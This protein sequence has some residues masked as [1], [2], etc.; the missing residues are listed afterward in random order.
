MFGGKTT[1]LF[2]IVLKSKKKSPFS[3]RRSLNLPPGEWL[4]TARARNTEGWSYAE[5]VPFMFQIP[6]EVSLESQRG[7]GAGATARSSLAM[8]FSLLLVSLL[9][10]LF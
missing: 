5:T 4:I 6:S 9:C 2:K 10:R 1:H 3:I 8:G 7:T